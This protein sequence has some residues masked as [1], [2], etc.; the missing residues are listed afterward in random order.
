MRMKYM[1]AVLAAL[2]VITGLAAVARPADEGAEDPRLKLPEPSFRPGASVAW[3]MELVPPPGWHINYL[4]PIV[5]SFDREALKGVPVA[6][7][8]E[9]FEFGLPDYA[10]RYVALLLFNVAPKAADGEYELPARVECGIC[11]EDNSA[12]TFAEAKATLVLRVRQAAPKSE[13]NQ[14][15]AKGILRS[16]VPL[17]QAE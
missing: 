13:K 17:L 8:Q 7:S 9:R 4:V 11:T 15:Q 3:E 16:S 6:L 10:E 2:A 1:S 12:C 14:A 5:V